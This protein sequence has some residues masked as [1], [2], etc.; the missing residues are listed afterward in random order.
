M[1]IGFSCFTSQ[2]LQTA[3]LRRQARGFLPQLFH[4]RLRR[5]SPLGADLLLLEDPVD[6]VVIQ[7]GI[8]AP[9]HVR[10]EPRHAEVKRRNHKFNETHLHVGDVGGIFIH[11]WAGRHSQA[12]FFLP[13]CEELLDDEVGPGLGDGGGLDGPRDV[14]TVQEHLH[15]EELVLRGLA[16]ALG[17]RHLPGVEGQELPAV[18][19]LEGV[20]LVDLGKVGLH[21]CTEDCLDH[22]LADGSEGLLVQFY[23]HVR[24]RFL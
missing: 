24:L 15:Q 19:L 2:L 18:L 23:Q 17:G 6:P 14:R 1:L 13:L 5:V 21:V 20:D 12:L 3:D 7:H 22:Q 16:E 11:H 9:C 4:L 10:E 8:Q